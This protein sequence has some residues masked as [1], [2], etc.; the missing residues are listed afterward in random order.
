MSKRQEAVCG[1]LLP[2]GELPEPHQPAEG[3]LDFPAMSTEAFARLHAASRNSRGD[4]AG[5]AS[6]PTPLGVVS[7]VRMEFLWSASGPT[8]FAVPDAVHG[9]QRGFELT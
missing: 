6:G 8:A 3:S 5:T 2:H 4:A 1:P 9:I 7:L